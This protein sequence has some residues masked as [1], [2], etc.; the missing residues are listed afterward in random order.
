M[1]QFY[2]QFIIFAQH[3]WLLLAALVLIV[4]LLF[5]EENKAKGAGGWQVKPQAAITLINRSDAIVVDVRPK[6][7]YETGH[8]VGAIN[9]TKDTIMTTL[10]QKKINKERYIILVCKLGQE[11]NKLI[12]Q[13]KKQGYLN[14][15]VLSGGIEAWKRAELPLV[16]KKRKK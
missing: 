10:S 6:T 8:I 2:S 12:F 13:I 5:L 14:V 7:A 3:N 15:K 11:A 16:K 9:S 1:G 4:F